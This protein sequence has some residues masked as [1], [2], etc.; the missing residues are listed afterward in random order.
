M[1]LIEIASERAGEAFDRMEWAVR[2]A[3]EDLAERRRGRHVGR[4][5]VRVAEA[6]EEPPAA[7]RPR[8]PR[9]ATPPRAPATGIVAALRAAARVARLS[10]L[11]ARLCLILL[12][13]AV[14]V[15]F[16]CLLGLA[17]APALA[18]A[19]SVAATRGASA[20]PDAV[21]ALR[22]SALGFLSSLWDGD[23]GGALDAVPAVAGPAGVGL[24]P[25]CALVLPLAAV[26]LRHVR[27]G[28]P[29][30]LSCGVAS[31][32]LLPRLPA[33][34]LGGAWAEA[35]RADLATLAVG[36]LL[37]A[38]CARLAARRPARRLLPR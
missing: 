28:L 2:D 14:A 13:E 6:S 29:A 7:P 23:W 38:S 3:L 5:R 35:P 9:V 8:A 17:A 26:A 16:F 12:D 20:S 11:V 31:A 25:C 33:A 34:V 37:A 30:L 18:A 1:T 4:V 22:A 24:L 36:G 19:A 21:A 32:T 10:Y 27:F 15:A